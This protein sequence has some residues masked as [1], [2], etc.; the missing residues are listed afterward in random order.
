MAYSELAKT[1][2]NLGQ[3]DDAEH[4]SRKAVELSDQLPPPEKYLIQASHD[5]ILRDYP[6]A[7][8][9]YDTLAKAAPDNTD[10]LFE[11]G[12]LYE[13]SSA[14][15][16]AREEYAKVLTLDPKRVSALLAMGRVEVYS[17]D[18]QKALEYLIR[19]QAWQS[20]SVTTKKDP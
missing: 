19:A 17:K 20:S 4:A 18:P 16:K 11:L 3:D 13:N 2:A 12:G 9:A 5:Q 7:I 14:Y 6:K 8:E 15:D 1:Y 10:V